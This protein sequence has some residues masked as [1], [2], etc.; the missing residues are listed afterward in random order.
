[1]STACIFLCCIAAL[2]QFNIKIWTGMGT[3]VKY[4][5]IKLWFAVITL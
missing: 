2:Q 1:M 5:N 4:K 3:I